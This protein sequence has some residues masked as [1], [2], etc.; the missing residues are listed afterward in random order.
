MSEKKNGSGVNN[1]LDRFI[2]DLIEKHIYEIAIALLVLLSLL[3]RYKLMTFKFNGDYIS[4]DFQNYLREWINLYREFGIAGG[5]GHTIGDYYVPYNIVLAVISVIPVF[6]EG[7]WISVVSIAGE[8]L[9]ALFMFKILDHLTG[10]KKI[11]AAFAAVMM[12]YLP[13]AMLNGSLWKQCDGLYTSFIFIGI[14]LFLK[15]KFNPAF[16]F[17]AIA[18]IFKLQT[19]FFVPFLILMYV[20]YHEFSILEF[21][22]FP[23]MYFLAGIP[24]LICG[25]SVYRTYI[26]YFKQTTVHKMSVGFPNV[27][28]LGIDSYEAMTVPALIITISVLIIAACFFFKNRDRIE[29]KLYFAMAGYL[30]MTCVMFLPAMHERYDYLAI[31]I[32]TMYALALDLYL[33]PAAIIMNICPIFTYGSYLFHNG[34]NLISYQLMSLMYLFAYLYAAAYICF[35]IKRYKGT[36]A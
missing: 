34:D 3:L 15:K 32:I 33:A 29:E 17:F 25:R 12:L 6:D 1:P 7:I 14:Y 10:G 19:L 24:A 2:T 5:L 35:R 13:M 18:F 22:W 20:L 8:Y 31:L 30:V 27:Y 26:T 9:G 4:G 11:R 16:I 23:V 21:L 28:V 36:A